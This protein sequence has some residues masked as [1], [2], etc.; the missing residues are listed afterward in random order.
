MVNLSG[1]SIFGYLAWP[2]AN[3]AVPL[4][5]ALS[6]FCIHGSEWLRLKGGRKIIFSFGVMRFAAFGAFTQSIWPL[7]RFLL[8]S[9]RRS[10]T[11]IRRPIYSF[12]AYCF[13]A[14]HQSIS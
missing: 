5:F 11:Q 8:A 10:D 4:F 9:M 12:M 3:I 2:G 14:S 7:S 13:T 6:G 1:L